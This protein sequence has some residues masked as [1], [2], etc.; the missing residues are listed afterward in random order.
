MKTKRC[1]ALVMLTATAALA[2]QAV[3]ARQNDWLI[4]PGKRL[5]PITSNTSRADLVRLF[6]NDN[7][8]DEPVDSGEGQEPA[9]VVLA[10]TPS[11]ALAVFWQSGR[12]DRVMVCYQRQAGPCHWHME[13]GVSLG[14]SVRQLEML[15]SRSFQI[16]AWGS[17]VGGNISSWRAGRLAS[18]F[19]EGEGRHVLLTMGWQETPGGLSSE[20]RRLEDEL[21]KQRRG[22]L[23]SD[24]AV[25]QLRPTVT[26]MMVL[27]QGQ[28]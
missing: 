10:K 28:E 19:G 13:D 12:I 2:Q 15:N 27:F 14:T 3:P 16:E 8:H 6:G 1:L 4:V 26:R 21:D 17:D 20:R 18:V 5:G 9:T 25:R 24:P 23:S 11:A 7:V 22:P